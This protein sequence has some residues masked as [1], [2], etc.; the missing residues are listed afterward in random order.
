MCLTKHTPFFAMST[1]WHRIGRGSYGFV[2]ANNDVACKVFVEDG[3]DTVP[4]KNDYC[5]N[6]AP[7]HAL[8]REMDTTFIIELNA[9]RLLEH[10]A[11]VVHALHVD[12]VKVH[13]LDDYRIAYRM[14]RATCDLRKLG[15]LSAQQCATMVHAM[16][17]AL[18][19]A[20][21]CGIIHGDIKP[22]NILMFETDTF[23]LADFGLAQ[24]DFDDVYACVERLDEIV[25]VSY[26]AP[27]LC[28]GSKKYNAAV[29]V[30]ALGVVLLEALTGVCPFVRSTTNEGVYA[31]W[32]AAF[33]LDPTT[34]QQLQE[35]QQCPLES[36][37][38]KKMGRLMFLKTRLPYVCADGINLLM[39]MLDPDPGQRYRA[40]DVA[41]HAFVAKVLPNPAFA[42]PPPI[43][44]NVISITL[45]DKNAS[46]AHANAYSNAL[47]WISHMDGGVHGSHIACLLYRFMSV[48]EV[49][50]KNVLLYAYACF[51]LIK[52]AFDCRQEEAASL[53]YF[54]PEDKTKA[55]RMLLCL[56][57]LEAE[58][59]KTVDFKLLLGTNKFKMI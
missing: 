2:V 23:K 9:L 32:K 12:C 59:V 20:H 34:E 30:F 15:K 16:S 41:R 44:D 52:K 8:S 13:G 4:M 29:D 40:E 25:T 58:V 35:T 42:A 17:S 3:D 18:A 26:R 27:E 21:E 11:Y 47:S 19:C 49:E 5:L 55:K 7:F 43:A 37:V 31:F 45:T 53:Q 14:P 39:H 38:F 28:V 33:N 54:C 24:F 56:I 36:A 1:S 46:V 57:K 10:C 22:H 50:V 6:I 48:V 51:A